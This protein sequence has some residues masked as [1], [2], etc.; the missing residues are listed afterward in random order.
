MNCH[1][2]QLKCHSRSPL[3]APRSGSSNFTLEYS[4]IPVDGLA[5]GET[6]HG[7]RC[8][9][10]DNWP[11]RAHQVWHVLIHDR[12]SVHCNGELS[13]ITFEIVFECLAQDDHPSSSQWLAV[14][15]HPSDKATVAFT[16]TA[17]E[18]FDVVAT[19]R[20]VCVLFAI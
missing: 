11:N 19:G 14:N 13:L 4:G 3:L 2:S 1:S 6:I 8:F 18:R 10:G 17:P 9:F 12:I 20:H 5:I 15:D 7:E 16:V